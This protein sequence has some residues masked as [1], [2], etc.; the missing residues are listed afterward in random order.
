MFEVKRSEVVKRC[1]CG[2]CGQAIIKGMDRSQVIMP[3][4]P[5]GINYHTEC[6][7]NYVALVENVDKTTIGSSNNCKT[8]KVSL[9]NCSPEVFQYFL[10][11]GFKKVYNGKCKAEFENAES[12]GATI[13]VAFKNDCKVYVNGKR[14]KSLEE[15]DRLTKSVCMR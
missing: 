3:F 12:I 5:R 15:Y 4:Q 7:E 13:K 11:Y 14:V 8:H 2:A 10:H 1:N 9:N 6:L